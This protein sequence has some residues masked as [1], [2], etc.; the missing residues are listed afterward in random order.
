[1]ERKLELGFEG[2]FIH[3]IKRTETTITQQGTYT[4]NSE[5]LVLPIPQREMD[6]NAV[7]TGQQN[8]GYGN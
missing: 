1:L 7:L 6:A 3:D 2:H 5:K 8:A 4:W